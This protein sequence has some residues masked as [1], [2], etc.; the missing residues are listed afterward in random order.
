MRD[1][2]WNKIALAEF[3]SLVCLT[4]DEEA[5]LQDWAAGDADI[6]YTAMR[7]HMSTRKVD[8]LRES[9]R[10]KYDEVQMYTPLLPKRQA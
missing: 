7:L 4:A 1:I 8:A 5:V 6:A 2:R 10:Q 3:R 9:I